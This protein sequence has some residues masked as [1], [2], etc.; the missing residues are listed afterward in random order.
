MESRFRR[1]VGARPRLG[2][3]WEGLGTG[4]GVLTTGTIFLSDLFSI[5]SISESMTAELDGRFF[6]GEEAS[7]SLS[8]VEDAGSSW[9]GELPRETDLLELIFLEEVLFAFGV[10]D[11][12]SSTIREETDGSRPTVGDGSVF[13]D[14]RCDFFLPEGFFF[15]EAELFAELLEPFLLFAIGRSDKKGKQKKKLLYDISPLPKE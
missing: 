15:G 10:F 7:V 1:C 5:I 2:P 11:S 3:S 6:L 14:D 9:I 13:P 4:S 8:F 12:G